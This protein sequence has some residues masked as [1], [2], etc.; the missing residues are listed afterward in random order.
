MKEAN[1]GKK[2]K[3]ALAIAAA[4]AA[5]WAGSK[6]FM[7]PQKREGKEVL[8]KAPVVLA[9]RGGAKLA[10]EHTMIA[11]EKAFELGVDGFEIDIRLT[12]D[13]EI[14]AFHDE[15]I[16]RTSD[17][18]GAVKDFTLEELKTLILVTTLK[19]RMDTTRIGIKKRKLSH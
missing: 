11:F 18:L 6:A 16:D 13:E 12:K 8:Q 14:V 7:K 19:M 9:H 17:G 4:S 3:L 2:T 15:T 10:P 5:A 1:H